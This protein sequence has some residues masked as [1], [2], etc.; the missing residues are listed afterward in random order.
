MDS[1]GPA[2]LRSASALRAASR[3]F[4]IAGGSEVVVPMALGGWLGDRSDLLMQA[5][6]QAQ[7]QILRHEVPTKT[8][9]APCWT[10][11]SVVIATWSCKASIASD[12]V[13]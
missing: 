11:L 12:R 2:G 1:G 13:E 7:P 5:S 9:E 8:S 3:T 10:Q 4:C 6:D